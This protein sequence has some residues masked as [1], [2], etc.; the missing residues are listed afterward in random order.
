MSN[1][2]YNVSNDVIDNV[3]SYLATYLPNYEV[4]KVMRK[5]A[6]Q[7]DNYLYMVVARHIKYPQIK[8]DYG[9]GEYTV[10]TCWNE[11]THSLNH[12]HYDIKTEEE[13]IEVAK[14]YFYN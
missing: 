5:S 6:H 11:S 10:W 1:T 12:G 14:K 13:A 3:K 9:G 4:V 7:A 8:R 2:M